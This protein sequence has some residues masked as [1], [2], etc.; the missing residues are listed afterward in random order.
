MQIKN[1]TIII[2]MGAVLVTAFFM[3]WFSG[4]PGVSA[5]D[6]VFGDV[7]RL[8]DTSFRFVFLIIPIAGLLIIYGAAFNNGSYSLSKRLVFL[9]PIVTLIV[10]IIAFGVTMGVDDGR[11]S[12][13]EIENTIKLLGFGFWLTLTASITL[14]FLN[15]QPA[16]KVTIPVKS[17]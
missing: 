10:I 15:S 7:G 3:P 1:K 13:S 5:W 6:I 11:M 16:K 17:D 12:G 9:L 4:F 14:L 2:T 8:L